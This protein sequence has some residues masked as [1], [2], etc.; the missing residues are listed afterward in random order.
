MTARFTP[1]RP[2]TALPEPLRP[3]GR[4]AKSNAAGR[5]E[6]TTREPFDDG[7]NAD[8]PSPEQLKTT[9]IRDSSRSIIATNDSPDISFERSIN[10]YRGCEHGC[11]YCYARPSHSYWG[12][13]AGLDFESVLFYKP[14]AAAL[15]EKTFR[16]PSYRVEPIVLG[17][18]TDVY[19]PV[20]RRLRITR[21]LLETCLKFRHPVSLITKSAS[22][23]RDLDLLS[24]LAALNL[25][26]TAVSLTTLDRKLARAMEPRAAT[27]ARR[28]EAMRALSDAGVPVT[29][30]T[31][32]IVPGLTDHEIE[33]LLEAAAEAGAERAGYVLLRLPL[34]IADL[35]KEWL[36]AE[37]PDAAKK[38]MSLV[39]QTRG[40]KDYDSRWGKRGRG[41]GPVA[42]LI[43]KRFR[44]AVRRYGLDGERRELRR[45]LFR[46]PLEDAQQLSLF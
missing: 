18:N 7:W 12:Y 36:A 10:P 22:I 11:V 38:I 32:P 23:T 1:A 26:K 27:P 33:A 46:R 28:L 35:F 45:D 3:R 6:P 30:M 4:G 34:E 24:E 41:E 21:S 9:L 13:S 8:D 43:A 39:R 44:A 17:A 31:A 5:Y 40:G 29:A 37:R 15:L 19:Q 20:E 2:S 16:K 25:V 14:D 42:A